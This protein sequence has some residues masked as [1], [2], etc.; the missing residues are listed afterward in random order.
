MGEATLETVSTKSTK[1]GLTLSS[2]LISSISFGQMDLFYFLVPTVI[3]HQ[4]PLPPEV[5]SKHFSSYHR[6]FS[7]HIVPMILSSLSFFFLDKKTENPVPPT[8]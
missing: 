3:Y 5:F 6:V 2:V 8:S 7:I 4:L 1:Q